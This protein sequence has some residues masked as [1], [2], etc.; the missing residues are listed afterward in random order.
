MQ[1]NIHLGVH[2]GD[3]IVDVNEESWQSKQLKRLQREA[4]VEVVALVYHVK[5]WQWWGDVKNEPSKSVFLR[6]LPNIQNNALA[7]VPF[8]EAREKTRHNL[9]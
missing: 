9:Q 4:D 3:Q 5:V 6:D 2:D 1:E 8:D 7:S